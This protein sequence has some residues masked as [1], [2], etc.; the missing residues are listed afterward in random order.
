MPK[1]NFFTTLTA[2]EK[3]ELLANDMVL[4][5][6]LLERFWRMEEFNSPRPRRFD[7][8]KHLEVLVDKGGFPAMR[9]PR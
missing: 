3:D 5:G 4:E 1:R 7:L 9:Y 2:A 6:K 8:M